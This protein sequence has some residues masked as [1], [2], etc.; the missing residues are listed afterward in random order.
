VWVKE[1]HV[2]GVEGHQFRPALVV[3][4]ETRLARFPPQRQGYSDPAGV[5]EAQF[6]A[7]KSRCSQGNVR[8]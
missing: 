8:P 1:R 2:V 6:W 4:H 3:K 7:D 5:S